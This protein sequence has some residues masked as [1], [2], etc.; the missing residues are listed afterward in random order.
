MSVLAAEAFQMQLPRM[1]RVRQNFADTHIEAI[2]KAVRQEIGQNRIRALI[3]PGQT[4]AVAVGSRGISN[5]DRVVKETVACLKELG[6]QPFI[7]PAMGSHGGATAEGQ[8]EVLRGY[9]ITEEAMGVTIKSSM[10]VTLLAHSAQGI[11]VYMDK[12]AY[13]AD[14]VVLINRIKPHTAFRGAIESGLCKM[15]A[16]GLGNRIGCE[17]LHAEGWE[18]FSELIT[19]V[20]KV[21]LER[22]NIGFGIALIENAYDQ[23]AI[24]KGI[25]KDE[26]LTEEPKLQAIS[27][28]MLPSLLLP[29]LDVLVV[30]QMGKDISGSG[31]DPNIIGR[32]VSWG[33]MP[34]YSGPIIKRI[35]VLD[36]TESSHGN[37]S[38]MGN[39]EFITRKFFAKIDFAAT[40]ANMI[41]AGVPT[42]ARLPIVIDSEEE[43]IIAAIKCCGKI[44]EGGPLIARIKDTLHL[45]EIWVSENMIPIISDNPKLE[46]V[47]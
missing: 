34:G 31:M 1:V 37:A 29:D 47:G 17:R 9:G 36:L 2:E 32:S 20:A 43:A 33:K 22:A 25:V 44:G 5:I 10:E 45:D 46:I 6:A 13:E 41:A 28:D 42:G 39:A 4:I 23:T 12:N 26:L 19:S 38:C 24:I 40:Y 14:M 18:D 8:L 7:V 27:K 35:V 11:P 30:E 21:I 15:L 3:K 16:I